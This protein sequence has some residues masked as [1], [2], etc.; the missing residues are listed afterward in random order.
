MS[1]STNVRQS[2]QS[3]PPAIL[4]AIKY[5][6]EEDNLETTGLFRRAASKAKVD[7]LKDLVEENP[8]E[9]DWGR[10]T[11]RGTFVSMAG[12]GEPMV[13]VTGGENPGEWGWGS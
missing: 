1:L 9:W 7:M 10:G 2:G 4:H 3:L 5:L 13:S 12:G 6:Q 8:G 11:L